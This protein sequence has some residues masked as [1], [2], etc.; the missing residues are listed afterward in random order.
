MRCWTGLPVLVSLMESEML[1]LLKRNSVWSPLWLISPFHSRAI[2][3]YDSAW[4]GVHH[5]DPCASATSLSLESLNFGEMETRVGGSNSTQTEFSFAAAPA[6]PQQHPWQ[7]QHSTAWILHLWPTPQCLP[8]C[9]VI[10]EPEMSW[11]NFHYVI[12]Q[13][14]KLL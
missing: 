6:R 3:G 1:H 2:V 7:V 8:S 13:P 12:I 10:M 5:L 4:G 9:L 14:V 11:L